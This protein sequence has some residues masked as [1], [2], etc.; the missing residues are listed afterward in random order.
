MKQDF[1][2]EIFESGVEESAE[3]E[4]EDD[5]QSILEQSF[6]RGY[7]EETI[8]PNEE[9]VVNEDLEY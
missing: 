5:G 9:K 6:T 7:E 8:D 1:D 2:E 4:E 3:L